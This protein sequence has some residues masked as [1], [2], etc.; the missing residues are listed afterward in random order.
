MPTVCNFAWCP[1]RQHTAALLRSSSAAQAE[2]E[3]AEGV[4]G[5]GTAE[6]T[7]LGPFVSSSSSIAREEASVGTSAVKSAVSAIES[8]A[9]GTF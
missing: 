3:D 8:A 9:G 5:E 1:Q 6:E 2:E 4:E 7:G